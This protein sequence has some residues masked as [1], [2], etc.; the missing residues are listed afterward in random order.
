MGSMDARFQEVAVRKDLDRRRLI[1]GP[2][3]YVRDKAHHLLCFNTL[4]KFIL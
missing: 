3:Y 1:A 2:D 4:I